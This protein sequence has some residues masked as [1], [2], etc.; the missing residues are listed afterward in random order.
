MNSGTTHLRPQ[1]TTR[2]DLAGFAGATGLAEG[3]IRELIDYGLLAADRLDMRTALVVREAARM[4]N[5]FDLDLFTTGL[6]A[7][8][9]LRIA[10]L[11]SELRRLR[12]ERPA[13]VVYT[14][15]AY[16]AVVRSG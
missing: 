9:L 1:D 5:D 8:Q 14:E 6:L 4:K 7:T 15:V 10:D 2:M 11:E 16:T 3:D 13:R 12:A